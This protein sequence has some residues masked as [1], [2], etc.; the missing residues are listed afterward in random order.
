MGYKGMQEI[1][2]RKKKGVKQCKKNSHSHSSCTA[3]H[4]RQRH[5]KHLQC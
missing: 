4:W 2:E 1:K 3:W 5:Y